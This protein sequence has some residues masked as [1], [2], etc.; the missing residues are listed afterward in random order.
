MYMSLFS[1]NLH[2]LTSCAASAES[3]IHFEQPS[4]G[5]DNINKPA[6]TK[7]SPMKRT[8][9]RTGESW[10]VLAEI[11]GE[12]VELARGTKIRVTGND[13][14]LTLMPLGLH[15]W[16]R[17]PVLH[18]LAKPES[19]GD[20]LWDPEWRWQ[21]LVNRAGEPHVVKLGVMMR[22]QPKISR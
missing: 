2:R 15:D 13:R 7:K 16:D 5:V 17:D 21:G 18:R 10:T 4:S 11:R 12:G 19:T 3:S 1:D 22:H 14:Q 6:P 8:N 9:S 20:G